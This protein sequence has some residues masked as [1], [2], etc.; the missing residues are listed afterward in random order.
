[1]TAAL[2]MD[3]SAAPHPILE[4]V[5][6][7]RADTDLS[8]DE[9]G[10]RIVALSGRISAATSRWLLLVADFDS[11]RGYDS[12]YLPSTARWLAHHCGIAMRTAMDHVRVAR[13]LARAPQLSAEMR[14]GR[15]SYTQVRAISRVMSKPAAPAEPVAVAEATPE[16]A[17]DAVAV[18]DLIE[19]AE[20]GTGSQLEAV[21]RGMRTVADNEAGGSPPPKEYFS[22]SWTAQSQWRCH[23][24]LDPDRGAVVRGVLDKIG[25]T[26]HISQVDALV[27]IAEIALAA[28]N[29]SGKPPRGLRGHE[30]AAVL[31]HLDASAVP[32][33]LAS[34]QLGA[35]GSPAAAH[36]TE[37]RP[38][39][40]IAD[41]PG[42]R[43][44]VVERL[45]CDGRIRTTVHDGEGNVRDL[46]R[47]HRVVTDRL[48]RVLLLRHGSRCA[49]PGCRN[50][51]GLHAHHVRHW[52]D[53]GRT[54]LDNLILLCP[55]HHRVHHEG[56]F[57]IE[58]VDNTYRFIRADGR[59]LADHSDPG[60]VIDTPVPIEAEQHGV[61]YRA[62]TSRW[63]GE[64]LDRHYAISVLAGRRAA[65]RRHAGRT[66]P[67]GPDP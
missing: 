43:R 7:T 54:D 17:G 59:E 48:F 42:L 50:R 63:T 57:A 27:R 16:A 46:G 24:R 18:A 56:G 44:D 38:F 39:A 9:L 19:V 36:P 2:P 14:A 12:F 13:A 25:T 30:R 1:M 55:R 41:G 8:I 64:H 53:G 21:V 47:A 5:D 58:R 20:H 10:S 62:A 33:R 26:E 60:L 15:L 65:A 35:A 22:Q 3:N 61:S 49:Y 67:A 32:H 40:R 37:E 11:R 4:I 66:V 45:L 6:P 28:L 51:L 31:I 23:A 34:D 29:D 52:L